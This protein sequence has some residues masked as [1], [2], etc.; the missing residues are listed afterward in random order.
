MQ[1]TT[2]THKAA[3]VLAFQQWLVR[4]WRINLPIH[5]QITWLRRVTQW[6]HPLRQ[7]VKNPW[8]IPSWR[9]T[10]SNLRIVG[11]LCAHLLSSLSGTSSNKCLLVVLSRFYL[12]LISRLIGSFLSCTLLK[13]LL[14][15]LYKLIHLD[16]LH[17]KS[18]LIIKHLSRPKP[19]H[20]FKTHYLSKSQL[21]FWCP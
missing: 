10:L 7:S 6:W 8:L 3:I 21:A 1:H 19:N 5:L 17:L 16:W 13:K 20:R 14:I 18:R 12:T 4:W 9:S 2:C 15:C 11:I